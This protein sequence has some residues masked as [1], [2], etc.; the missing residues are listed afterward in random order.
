MTQDEFNP[1]ARA[2]HRIMLA[3]WLLMLSA[4]LVLAISWATDIAPHHPIA[5]AVEQTPPRAGT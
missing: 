3:A 2:T 4:L 5:S 1:L